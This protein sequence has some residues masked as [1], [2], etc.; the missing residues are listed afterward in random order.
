MGVKMIDFNTAN[1][2]EVEHAAYQIDGYFQTDHRKEKSANE[3][4]DNAKSELL[5]HL[6]RKL[7]IAEEMPF[8]L[9]IKHKVVC[10]STKRYHA[11]YKHKPG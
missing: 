6:R 8:E 9:F 2:Y 7:A 5:C 3:C 10:N 11:E 1:F 4:F